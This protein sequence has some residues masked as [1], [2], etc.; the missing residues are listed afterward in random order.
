MSVEPMDA[1]GRASIRPAELDA[2]VGRALGRTVTVTAWQVDPLAVDA[3]TTEAVLHLHGTAQ[4]GSES[5]PWDLLVKVCRAPRHWPLLATVPQAHRQAFI[6]GYPWRAEFDLR[7]AGAADLMPGGLRLPALYRSDELGDDRIAL[8]TEWIDAEPG[9]WDTDRYRRAAE[10]LGRMTARW[11][12]LPG[13]T[14]DRHG[15]SQS[16]QLVDGPVRQHLVPRATD[17]ALA[18]HPLL[19]DADIGRL[20]ADMVTL[21]DRLPALVDH[22]D[23][24]E[25]AIGHGDACPQ[26]LLVSRTDPDTL[27]AIDL[28]WP[29]PEAIGY[30][31]G[32]L[33][34]GRAHTGELPVEAMPELRVEIVNGFVDGLRLE[35][36]P[37]SATDVAFAF[38]ASLVVRS[39][40]LSFPFDILDQPA[41]PELD[42]AVTR[43]LE[44]ARYLVDLGLAMRS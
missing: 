10:L 1:L 25:R 30:D 21:A 23:A 16:R 41:T 28:S 36:C 44:L 42:Q 34:V 18:R 19:V 7:S 8:W 40:F 32:Q 15:P 3:I 43:R 17:P 38:D 29:Y 24:L 2:V 4:G 20:L 9:G 27:V 22:F 13:S 39:A 6:D 31:L 11:R 35:G 33:L 37:V 14:A 5:L 26:N 12:A